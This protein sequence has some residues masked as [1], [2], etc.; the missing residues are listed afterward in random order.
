[1]RFPDDEDDFRDSIF[2]VS[3]WL[4]LEL[5]EP[6]TGIG[7]SMPVKGELIFCHMPWLFHA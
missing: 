4:V 1:L 3:Y 2:S 5:F 6:E 7:S